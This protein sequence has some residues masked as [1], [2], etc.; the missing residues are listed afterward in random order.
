MAWR[1][2]ARQRNGTFKGEEM[3]TIDYETKERLGWQKAKSGERLAIEAAFA[4]LEVGERAGYEAL[5]E[6]ADCEYA[7]A[8]VIAGVVKRA[9]NVRGSGARFGTL[10]R[11]GIVRLDDVGI[12]GETST[13]LRLAGKKSRRA[14]K[15]ARGV[16]LM[17]LSNEARADHLSTLAVAIAV[18]DLTRSNVHDALTAHAGGAGFDA[19]MPGRR[20]VAG[21][22][23]MGKPKK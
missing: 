6:A 21:L 20:A 11:I 5:A 17:A 15:I 22:L 4:A 7:R 8:V 1:G 12:V 14:V 3:T 10:H 23:E 13:H 2:M 16:N 18:G 9:L 19:L